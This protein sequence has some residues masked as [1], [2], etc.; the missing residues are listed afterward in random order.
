MDAPRLYRYDRNFGGLD[1][2]IALRDYLA[3]AFNALGKTSTDVRTVPRAMGKLLKEAERVKLILSANSECYAQVE[4]LL[5]E[6]DFKVKVTRD[7]FLEMTREYLD[8]DRLTAPVAKALEA[9]GVGLPEVSEVILVGAG[10]RVPRVQEVLGAFLGDGK[11]LGKSL[12]TDEAAAMG[13]VYRA[14]DLS[15]AFKVKKFVTKDAVLFPIDVDFQRRGIQDEEGKLVQKTLFSKMN[16]FPQKKVMT[17]NK[18]SD[19]FDFSVNIKHLDHLDL[20]ERRFIGNLNLSSVKVKGVK[21]ALEKH[22]ENTNVENK[23]VKAHF[24][25]DDS[26]LLHVTGVEAAFEE[27][28]SVEQQLQEELEKEQAASA[29][30]DNDQGNKNGSSWSEKLGESII[31]LFGGKPCFIF[32]KIC[33]VFTRNN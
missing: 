31:N 30:T 21:A 29:A 14:A 17:F 11:D 4:N 26:G 8:P 10:T 22:Q 6:I 12:N 9:A 28:I 27:T 24:S 5:E 15:S 3:D 18:F 19:D 7:S 1:L 13:A 20:K 32:K 25:V 16:P 33:L 23:G 2:K